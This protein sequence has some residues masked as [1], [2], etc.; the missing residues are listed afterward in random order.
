MSRWKRN[1]IK[2]NTPTAEAHPKIVGDGLRDQQT[3][4]LVSLL[5]P[6]F[7][8][9]RALQGNLTFEIQVGQVLIAPGQQVRDRT[10]HS[11]D[12]WRSYFDSCGSSHTFSTFTKILTSNGLDIDRA[13]NTTGESGSGRLWDPVPASQSITYEFHCHSRSNEEFQIVIDKNG[14]YEL[15][16]GLATVGAINIHVPAQIWDLSASLS[17]P[18]KWSD[19]PEAVAQSVKAFVDSVYLP[20][21]RKHL[22]LFF[23]QPKDH[24][25][26]V[27]N[28]I[29]KR[30]SYHTSNQ[31]DGNGTSMKVVEAKN[32]QFRVHQQDKRL[33]QAYE[34]QPEK[35]DDYL[36]KVADGGRIH[37]EMS[38]VHRQ[39]NE[40]L[41]K[42]KFLEIGELTDAGTTG[43]SLLD[44]N[45]IRSMLDIAVQLVSKIDYVGMWNYGTQKRIAVE[46]EAHQR[47][48][49]AR[50]G[51]RGQTAMQLSRAHGSSMPGGSRLISRG[52]TGTAAGATTI[53]Q[54]PLPG[55]RMNTEAE[56]MIDE[57]GNRYLLGMGGARVPIVG[58]QE[59]MD[60]AASVVPDDSASQ[61]GGRPQ[62]H[63]LYRSTD[64][65]DGFW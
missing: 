50:L 2:N 36:L 29:V 13:L 44:H 45:T 32:L 23:R 28:L 18:L 47:E 22:L 11:V 43:K 14:S 3:S 4:K 24:E 40:V 25:I 51:P 6:V 35:A 63:A 54:Q 42:N 56:L 7:E 33:W 9:G 57:S 5:Q 1:Q 59:P 27:R 58:D 41:A 65:G 34:V 37:Y 38:L 60:S 39:I 64:K 19:P 62:L 30:V 10:Y 8:A 49:A 17:G 53:M 16:K 55:V 21:S 20:P 31:L 61:V 26:K 46:A 15:R 12:D 48:L 52:P